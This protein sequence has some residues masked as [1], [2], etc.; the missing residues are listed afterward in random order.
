M[1]R[2]LRR[3][4]GSPARRITQRECRSVSDAGRAAHAAVPA[5]HAQRLPRLDAVRRRPSRRMCCTTCAERASRI[6]TLLIEQSLATVVGSD[7]NHLFSLARRSLAREKHN[8]HNCHVRISS[9]AHGCTYKRHSPDLTSTRARIVG[10]CRHRAGARVR[11]RTCVRSGASQ[12]EARLDAMGSLRM[13][14]PVAANMALQTAGA[15]HGVPGSPMPP[16]GASLGTKC[17][18][19]TGISFIRSGS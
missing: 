8:S 5:I 18:S 7:W 19:T 1:S 10:T 16:I 17:V 4:R 2:T 3:A 14:L 9:G 15:M 13:R 12:A 11:R 6:G